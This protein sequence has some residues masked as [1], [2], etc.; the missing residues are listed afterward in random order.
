VS[1]RE[2]P[3]EVQGTVVAPAVAA[4]VRVTFERADQ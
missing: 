1:H 4:P 2:N 3:G